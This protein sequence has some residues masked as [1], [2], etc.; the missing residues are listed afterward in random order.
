MFWLQRIKL[1]F[2]EAHKLQGYFR[3]TFAL[4]NETNQD[5]KRYHE[6]SISFFGN[7]SN[8]VSIKHNSIS[9]SI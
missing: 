3:N 4:L 8:I 5:L 2:N 7:S 9:L 1:F 6:L